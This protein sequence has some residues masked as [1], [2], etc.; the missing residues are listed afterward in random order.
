MDPQSSADKELDDMIECPICTE[1]FTDPRVLPCIHTFCFECLLNYGKGR[2]PGDRMPCPMCRKEFTI[3]A[4]GLPGMQKNFEKEKLL[5]VR[6]RLAGQKAQRS[7]GDTQRNMCEQ[8]KD[9]QIGAFCRDCKV[10]VCLKCVIRSHNTHDCLDIEDLRKLVLS[11]N[12]KISEAWKKTEELRQRIEKEKNDVIEHLDG[13]EDE[14]NTATDKLI[15]AI[16]R[17]KAKLLSEVES[18]KTKR[19]EQLKT[20]KQE[21]EEH[22]TA[23]VSFVRYSETLLSSGTEQ[24]VM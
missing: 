2:R 11:D 4:N 3:P 7:S 12:H 22:I 6:K 21:L 18:I 10:A 8:H 20:V 5:H 23:L 16:Q 19:V 15:A 24:F 9:K 13:V 14:I 17:D 1:V